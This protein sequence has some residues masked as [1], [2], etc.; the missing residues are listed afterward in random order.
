VDKTSV[1]LDKK[2]VK[3]LM[4]GGSSDDILCPSMSYPKPLP[5]EKDRN[6]LKTCR[7]GEGNH[8][9]LSLSSKKKI[10]PPRKFRIFGNHR[11]SACPDGRERAIPDFPILIE[12]SALPQS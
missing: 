9:S 5:E 6:P 2:Q 3:Q 1:S 7:R 8:P 10:L 4:R 12:T 11:K